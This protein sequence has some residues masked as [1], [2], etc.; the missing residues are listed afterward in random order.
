LVAAMAGALLGT[1]HGNSWIP[2]RWYDSIENGTRVTGEIVALAR[3]LTGR[4]IRS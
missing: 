1:L 3:R 2:A 4:D